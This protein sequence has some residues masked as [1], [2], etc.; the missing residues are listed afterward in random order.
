MFIRGNISF[1]WYDC[2]ISRIIASFSKKKGNGFALKTIF[3]FFKQGSLKV[4]YTVLNGK[5]LVGVHED[6]SYLLSSSLSLLC[7]KTWGVD[8]LSCIRLN[9]ERDECA[10]QLRHWVICVPPLF[11]ENPLRVPEFRQ[12]S[13]FD[14]DSMERGQNSHREGV[15]STHIH[16]WSCQLTERST[17]HVTRSLGQLE[18]CVA[19][20]RNGFHTAICSLASLTL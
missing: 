11:K 15:I 5:L 12:F 8:M 3:L 10:D 1:C 14:T 9:L 16:H 18:L 2:S 13:A 19:P 17:A 6:V 20:G 4:S 7:N